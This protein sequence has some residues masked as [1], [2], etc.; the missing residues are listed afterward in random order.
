M[1]KKAFFRQITENSN[2]GIEIITMST[3]ATKVQRRMNLEIGKTM[4]Y[5]REDDRVTD[6]KIEKGE[7]KVGFDKAPLVFKY[8]YD[9]HDVEEKYWIGEPFIVL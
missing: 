8:H 5:L 4:R 9:D 7:N 1:A 2:S 3:D 6:L